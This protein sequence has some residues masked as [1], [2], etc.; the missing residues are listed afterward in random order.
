MF[1]FVDSIVC[2]TIFSSICLLILPISLFVG[3]I[4]LQSGEFAKFDLLS[5]RVKNASLS[6]MVSTLFSDYGLSAIAHSFS[7]LL[8]FSV[9]F[10]VAFFY[11][12]CMFFLN[13]RFILFW[14]HLVIV[15]YYIII[16]SGLF[17]IS[18]KFS[19]EF[20]AVLLV[21]FDHCN[22]RIHSAL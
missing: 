2:F 19:L 3:L 18:H 10:V 4:S 21:P 17:Q 5:F 14:L 7:S 6:A 9:S 1:T 12:L 8:M 20:T 13:E 22:H 11:A 15:D 16:V